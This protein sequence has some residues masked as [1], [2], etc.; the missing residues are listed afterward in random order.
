MKAINKYGVHLKLLLI[1]CSIF[2]IGLACTL[3]FSQSS[4][5]KEQ[6]SAE[7]FWNG[8]AKLYFE[9]KGSW[10]GLDAKLK[11]DRYMAAGNKSLSIKIYNSAGGVEVVAPGIGRLDEE[12]GR[13]IP[14]LIDGHVV[15]YTET[16][17]SKQPILSFMNL[18]LPLI[19]AAL[20]FAYGLWRMSRTNRMKELIEQDAA[21][22][23]WE[24]LNYKSAEKAVDFSTNNGYRSD[25]N[26]VLKAIDELVMRVE[27]LE[28]VR[29]T[30]VA[31]IAHELRTPIA[32]MRTQLDNAIGDGQ[33]LPLKK[34]VS[35]HD[36]TLRLTK[37]VRDLQELSLAESDHLPLHKTW[38]SLT[39]LVAA[40]AETLVVGTEDEKIM[41]RLE[42]EGDVLIFGDETRIRQVIIN[43]I[44]NAIGHAR[45][46]L[47]IAVRQ[48]MGQAE[49]MIKDDGWGIEEEE[50]D[51][52][53]DRFYRGKANVEAR[54]RGAGLGLG[55]AIAK[56]FA[57]AHKGSLTVNSRFGEGA[58][59]TLALPIII[60]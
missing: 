21:H 7:L 40:V 12:S 47:Q 45:T 39:E 18:G 36:E 41:T 56:Q 10:E 2:L 14:V 49:V 11:A 9:M 13:Q 57:M 22:A 27:R 15:G 58:A 48:A 30:M 34:I 32:I 33:A 60:E 17:I 23:V 51:Y 24:R 35:L 6:T 50:L 19:L 31:D 43:L 59:F 52:V 55:L 3:G 5:Q 4:F 20:V 38:F 25:F 37:L 54:K 16:T 26:T 28:T 44:G 42:M 46:E 53:F 29:R 8:Y 1:T